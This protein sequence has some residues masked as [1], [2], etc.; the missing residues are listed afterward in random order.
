[1]GVFTLYIRASHRENIAHF[2]AAPLGKVSQGFMEGETFV[3]LK[4][5]V[6]G[7]VSMKVSHGVLYRTR[8]TLKPSLPLE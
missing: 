5:K 1:M 4:E 8:E 2:H 3:R 7:K 6:K